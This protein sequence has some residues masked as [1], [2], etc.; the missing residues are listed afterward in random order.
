MLKSIFIKMFDS[1]MSLNKKNIL[2]LLEHNPNAFILDLGCDDGTWTKVMSEK[3]GSQE[4]FGVE[5]VKE[6]IDLARKK[7][8]T[9]KKADLNKKLPFPDNYFDVV[10]ANQVIEHLSEI[11]LF[12]HEIYR[13]L[14]KGGYVII[15]TENASSWH[16]IFAS[17]MGWQIF[18]LTNVSAKGLGLGNP[19]AVHSGEKVHLV[20]WVHKTIFNYYGLEDLFKIYNFKKII[21][22]GEGYYPLLAIFGRIDPIH[23]HFVTLKCRK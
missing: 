2:N 3:I 8:I 18:S 5:V 13:V 21:I 1:A 19:M 23:S 7:G 22:V 16:N 11:D 6:R 17:I 10:H 9:V 20:T 4:I 12:V 15:S 14:K